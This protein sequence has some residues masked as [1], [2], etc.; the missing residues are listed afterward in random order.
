MLLLMNN[1]KPKQCYLPLYRGN[2]YKDYYTD[3]LLLYRGNKRR[4][5][6]KGAYR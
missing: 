2:T 6:Y 4:N 3:Y 1:E 5:I